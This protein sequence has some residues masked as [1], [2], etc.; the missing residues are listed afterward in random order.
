MNQLVPY[1]PMY[2]R[3][4]GTLEAF[5]DLGFNNVP[6]AY[7]LGQLP[8]NSFAKKA[9]FLEDSVSN[10]LDGLVQM[11]VSQPRSGAQRFWDNFGHDLRGNEYDKMLAERAD[12]G[13]QVMR[14]TGMVNAGRHIGRFMETVDSMCDSITRAGGDGELK[15]A[16]YKQILKNADGSIMDAAYRM[17][18]VEGG[19]ICDGIDLGAI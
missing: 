15:R 8:L 3:P 7:K 1:N 5:Q 18:R 6:T 11:S 16:K 10:A 9:V 13:R 17:G 14:L 19:L 2:Q 4:G 12:Q